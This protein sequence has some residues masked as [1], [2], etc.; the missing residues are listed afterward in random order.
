M[1]RRATRLMD[2]AEY[3]RLHEVAQLNM[4]AKGEVRMGLMSVPD[5]EAPM[6]VCFWCGEPIEILLFGDM[7]AAQKKEL[8]A[9][10][11]VNDQVPAMVVTDHEPCS[12]CTEL[13]GRGVC[14]MEAEGTGARTKATG[15]YWVFTDSVINA[16]ISDPAIRDSILKKRRALI[17]RDT[18]RRLGFY[19]M[20]PPAPT[21]H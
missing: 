19:D 16:M 9:F 8:E 13:M 10:N 7:P 14:I 18:A 3:C 5:Y 4:V 2:S 12:A 17:D 11:A 20:E 1:R 15:R 21:V 6:R